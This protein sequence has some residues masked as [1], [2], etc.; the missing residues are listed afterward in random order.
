MRHLVP[1]QSLDNTYSEDE[2][3]EFFQRMQKLLPET[4]IPLTVEPK[5][6]GVAISLLYED[7]V[8]VRAATRGD[9]VMGDD[10]TANIKTIRSI[11]QKLKGTVPARWEIRGEVY[12]PKKRFAKINEERDEQGCRR[13][14][15]REIARRGR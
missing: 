4:V 11:P 6:D 8:L 13:L 9:G 15:I 5:V 10:V 2:V 3:R 14:R 12:L 7:G 1:M